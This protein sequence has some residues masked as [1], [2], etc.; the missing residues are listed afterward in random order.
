[1]GSLVSRSHWFDNLF[2]ELSPGFFIKP[3]DMEPLSVL[4]HIR[5]DLQESDKAYTLCADLPGVHKEDIHV[6]LGANLVTLSAEV[7]H[8]EKTSS[9]NMV[10]S[11]RHHG[12]MQRSISLACEIDKAKASAH[13][14][15][16]VLTLTLPK[17]ESAR[18]QE[19]KID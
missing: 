7:R 19:L 1:M 10:R 13:Y 6:T 5:M 18:S 17:Q 11:E 9:G 14:E 8:A 12:S 3:M 16:G 2:K 15:N 4:E